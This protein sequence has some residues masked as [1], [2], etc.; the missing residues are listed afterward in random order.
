M[1][2]ACPLPVPDDARELLVFGGSFDPPTRAHAECAL[3]A[4]D[5]AMPRAWL[6]L[7]PAAR[8]PHKNDAPEASDADRV[9]MLELAFAGAGRTAIW[10]DELDRADDRASPSYAID[11]IR[12][13]GSIRP[14]ATRRLLIGADQALAFCRWKEHR[15]LAELAEPLVLLRAPAESP[16]E[17]IARLAQSDAWSTADLDA[18]R[19]RIAPV[20]VRTGSATEARRLLASL[21]ARNRKDLAALLHPEVLVYILDRDLYRGGARVSP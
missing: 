18:W 2:P 10:T 11:T 1:P 16:D 14:D 5:A 13:L 6:V 8:S 20:P 4:R 19:R 12:R 15:E 3:E 21:R 17:L 7:V 9:R